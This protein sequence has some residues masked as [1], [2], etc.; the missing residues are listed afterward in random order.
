MRNYPPT[1][2]QDI[3]KIVE[4]L[5][6]QFQLHVRGKFVEAMAAIDINDIRSVIWKLLVRVDGQ[7]HRSNIRL[8]KDEK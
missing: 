3:G 6:K 8:K 4:Y 1:Y 2:K 5:K 7:K